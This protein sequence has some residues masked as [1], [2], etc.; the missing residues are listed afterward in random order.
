VATICVPLS[1]VSLPTAAVVT[2]LVALARLRSDGELTALAACGAGALRVAAAP[3]VACAVVAIAAGSL[4]LFAEPAAYRSLESRLGALLARAALGRIRP[5]VIV[6]PVPALTVLA[7]HRR[8]DT[9]E[10]VVIED[11]RATPAA[12]LVAASAT[13]APMPGRR[14]VR[15]VLADG[16]VHSRAPGEGGRAGRLLI[17][18]FSRLEVTLALDEAA[19]GDG[20]LATLLPRRLGQGPDALALAARSGGVAGRE[21]ALLLHRRLA[22]GPGAFALCLVALGLGLGV[23]LASRPWAAALGAAL[24]LGYHLLSRL[25]EALVAAGALPAPAGGWLPAVACLAAIAVPLGRRALAASDGP[26]RKNLP[27]F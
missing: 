14:A 25:G 5:G 19:G 15:L 16:E 7:R 20:G 9:L 21:A 22:V 8:G 6:E 26:R 4:S 11:R 12:Q 13:L 18:S 10:G 24:V 2:V 23:R 1:A 17:A 27:G 3:A